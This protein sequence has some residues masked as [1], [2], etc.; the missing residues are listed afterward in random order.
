MKQIILTLLFSILTALSFGQK[1]DSI[2]ASISN[3]HI[4]FHVGSTTGIGLSYRYWYKKFGIQATGFPVISKDF[5]TF[6]SAG[7]SLLYIL[8]DNKKVDLFGYIGNHIINFNDK[9]LFNLGVGI[10]LKIDF[11]E[12]L[13]FSLQTGYGI[14]NLQDSPSS[15]LTGEFGLYYHL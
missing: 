3:H 1:K 11:L 8:K 5:G 15:L 9:P 6:F 2:D 7:V 14:Y 4:G 13:D 10:G 12:V